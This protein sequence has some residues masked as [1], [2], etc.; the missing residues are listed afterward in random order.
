LA[1]VNYAWPSGLFVGGRGGSLA[2]FFD[3]G[4]AEGRL[5]LAG[6]G[7]SE[8]RRARCRVTRS[9]SVGYT[10]ETALQGVADGQCNRKQTARFAG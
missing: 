1:K 2:A 8:L 4:R 5:R 10:R 9:L 6:G 3:P 7:K